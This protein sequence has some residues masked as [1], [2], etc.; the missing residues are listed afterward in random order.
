MV[1]HSVIEF[2]RWASRRSSLPRAHPG[3]IPTSSVSS[4]R[5]AGNVWITLSSSTTVTCA[6]SCRAIFNIIMKPE[7]IFRLTRNA[8]GLVLYSYPPQ[9]ITLSPSRRS[10][11]CTIAMSVAPR[12]M[13]GAAP[14]YLFPPN[15]PQFIFEQGQAQRSHSPAPPSLFTMLFQKNK[16]S[17]RQL[18]AAQQDPFMRFFDSH[19]PSRCNIPFCG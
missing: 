1:R 14:S 17:A 18:Q 7:R 13:G 19:Y 3:R 8:H 4:V 12:E 15:C 11:A 9:A 16:R 5:S 2:A 10:A 6:A